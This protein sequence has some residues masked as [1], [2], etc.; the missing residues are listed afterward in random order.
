WRAIELSKKIG[1]RDT[2]Y[3]RNALVNSLSLGELALVEE[4]LTGLEQMIRG[5]SNSVQYE[6][7]YNRIRDRL[8][9]IRGQW[10][11]ALQILR[12]MRQVV[13]EREDLQDVFIYSFSIAEILI[14]LNRLDEL[15]DL[16]E[17]EASLKTCIEIAD[18]GLK[19]KVEPRCLLCSVSARQGRFKDARQLLAEVL[20]MAG[21]E[22]TIWDEVR[23]KSAQ[24]EL[25]YLEKRW[26]DSI[27]AFEATASILAKME[28]RPRWARTLMLWAD[29]HIARAE[30][31]DK[32]QA[33]DLLR[34]ALEAYQDMEIPYWVNLVEEKLEALGAEVGE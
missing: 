31:G 14:E 11:D 24:A 2:V 5:T 15:G 34:Q 9:A 26:E 6:Q 8:M 23:I 17:A 7:L 30:T 20:E 32:E 10:L 21:P 33:E 19:S 3:L 18:R 1:S 16:S 27:N 28:A 13:S 4:A 25:A 12:N 22:P 29:V